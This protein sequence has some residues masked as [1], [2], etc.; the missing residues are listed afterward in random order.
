MT[1]TASWY[2][3]RTSTATPWMSR[4]QRRWLPSR[5]SD[6]AFTEHS[7]TKGARM[8]LRTAALAS[9]IAAASLWLPASSGA[10]ASGPIEPQFASVFGSGMVLPYGEPV[11]L[12]GHAAPGAKL[13][14]QVAERDY[15]TR[16]DAH[17]QWR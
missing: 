9:C 7:P 15:G 14:V 8:R 11:T 10:A 4:L 12:S 16:S 2:R 1:C 17:G 5:C 6:R 3:C 13:L